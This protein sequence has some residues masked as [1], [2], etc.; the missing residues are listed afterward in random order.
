MGFLLPLLLPVKF[1]SSLV[2]SLDA[3]GIALGGL[4]APYGTTDGAWTEARRSGLQNGL[5]AAFYAHEGF[6]G[7]EEAFEGSGAF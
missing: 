7:P 4:L 5:M 6:K 3:F 2:S 1:S